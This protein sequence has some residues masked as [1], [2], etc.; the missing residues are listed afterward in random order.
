MKPTQHRGGTAR[1]SRVALLV[2]TAA[3]LLLAGCASFGP[4]TI[5]ADRMNYDQAVTES[6][7]RQLLLNLV[8]LRYGDAPMFLDVASIIN[9]YTLEAQINVGASWLNGGGADSLTAGGLGHFAD[10]PT[11]TYSPMIGERF[12]RSLMTP[13][14]PGVVLSLIQSGWAADAVFRAMVSSI[15]GIQNRY[16]AAG[17]R[18]RGADPEFY[19]LIAALREVQSTGA[20]G[21]RIER[22]K[23]QEWT[24]LSIPREGLQPQ[25]LEASRTIREV[26]GIDP[27]KEELR[28]VYGSGRKSDDEIA[29]ITR[30]MLEILIDI[31]STIEVPAAHVE[32]G[33]TYKTPVFESDGP[34][35]YKPMM[36]IR[37]A[38]GKPD[39]AYAAVSYRGHWFWVDD[40]DYRTKAFHSL[41]LILMS[42][43][44]TGP[45]KGAPI[46]T[47]PAG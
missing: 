25:A 26:L 30:S 14:P 17:P 16:G 18:A 38:P 40:R 6:W 33:R 36:Q 8:K 34:G 21:M 46:V 1:R 44:E 45:S 23:D 31:G 13:I 9:S 19:R 29:M 41:M 37:S 20:V 47:I 39:D 7:K 5:G 12:V 11:I 32:E 4:R 43:T 35:D 3:V 24:V 42:L 28:V 15:N 2:G 22:T 10:K 27:A